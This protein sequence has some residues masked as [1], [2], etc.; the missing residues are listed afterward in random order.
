MFLS[1]FI[2]CAL[3]CVVFC[4]VFARRKKVEE[5]VVVE[6]WTHEDKTREAL[7]N[8][9]ITQFMADNPGIV[10]HRVVHGSAEQVELIPRAF[11]AG[12]GPD[13]FNLPIENEYPFIAQG[14]VSPVDWKSAG[15]SSLSSLEETYIDG[16][17]DG[18]RKDGNIYGLPLEYTNWCLYINKKAF[19]EAGLDAEKDY[20]RTWED[21][22]SL[23][24]KLVVSDG[25]A[26]KKRGFDF[27][28]PYYLNFL[29]PMVEQLGGNLVGEDGR[30]ALPGE[31]AWVSVLSFMRQWGPNG[32]NLGSPTY[33]NARYSFMG[34]DATASM[35]LS[36]LYQESR[37]AEQ[38]PD[39]YDSGDWM[40]VPFPQFAQ[41]VRNV[42]SC[43]YAHYFMVNASSDEK[44]RSGAWKLVG[45]LLS[46]GEE[47]L[48][49]AS[50]LQ[51]TKA[52]FASSVL[53]KMPYSSVF[54]DDLSKSQLIYAGPKSSEIQDLLAVAVESVMLGDENPEKAYVT[55]KAGVQ[56]LL[57]EGA[58]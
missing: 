9:L 18:V 27:R 31:D 11:A 17:F 57:D 56:E 15:F 28:Y 48:T 32:L 1:I 25:S 38:Y 37:M 26:L 36:G 54:I 8:R 29:V 50:L 16:V 4:V 46:H 10:V 20:P 12:N 22:V 45:Y 55:L 42:S 23:S 41:A 51:P 19:R 7:E 24:E 33:Q 21:V 35:A 49:S 52:L 44:V 47:Y 30:T 3:V 13:L 34:D 43:T 6:Y 5:P 40:V 2:A 58:K 53:R 14:V 39:F